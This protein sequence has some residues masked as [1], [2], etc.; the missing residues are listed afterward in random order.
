[1]ALPGEIMISVCVCVWENDSTEWSEVL[2]THAKSASL[3]QMPRKLSET[4]RVL[5]D[6]SGSE[7]PA[8][9]S[10]IE[11]TSVHYRQSTI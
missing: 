1:M 8:T 9:Y 5:W 4:L 10:S 2:D 6:Y 11:N 3:T 7:D